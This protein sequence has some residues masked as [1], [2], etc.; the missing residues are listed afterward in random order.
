MSDDEFDDDVII[1]LR[2]FE[3][4]EKLKKQKEKHFKHIK[5]SFIFFIVGILLMPSLYAI[6]NC[7]EGL[8]SF[9]GGCYNCDGVL[10]K[11]VNGN[12]VCIKCIEGFEYDLQG[13]CIQ[14]EMPMDKDVGTLL[15]K[16]SSKISPENPLL[17]FIILLLLLII[18]VNRLFKKGFK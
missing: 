2:D 8:I 15:D 14:K 18:I 4:E 16:I 6:Q 3:L 11:R 12:I 9:D 13:G 10:Y 17:G 7:N 5:F 1:D